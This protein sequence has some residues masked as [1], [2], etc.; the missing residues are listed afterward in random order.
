MSIIRMG[1]VAMVLAA[2]VSSVW[3]QSDLDPAF[4]VVNVTGDCK[5]SLPGANDFVE[6]VESK[7]YP[8][9]SHIRTGA[10][11]SLVAIISEGN[12]VR[13]L[14]N[15]DVVFNHNTDDIKIKNIRL[16]DGEVEVDL[17]STFSE[18]GN[19][20]NVETATAICGAVGTKFNVGSRIVEDMRVVIMRVIRGIIRVHGENF[21]VLEMDADDVFSVLSPADQSYLRMKTMKGK[22]N[23]TFKDEKMEDKNVETTEGMVLKVW[24]R[25]VPESNQRIIH[26]QLLAPDGTQAGEFIFTYGGGVAPE[27]GKDRG[28]NPPWNEEDK[29]PRW[30]DGKPPRRDGEPG[31][32][33]PPDHILNDIVDLVDRTLNEE[34]IEFEQ[35][36]QQPR[37]QPPTPTPAGRR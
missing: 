2:L 34:N 16:N 20:L 18:G 11:S 6:A 30:R 13:V 17:K 31:N 15:A 25:F 8:Y 26:V 10:R 29:K 32:P 5:I 12:T 9:G 19:R 36:Q 23:V 21:E 1:C 35:Q 3:A 22:L 4:R 14:A 28:A 27:F 37:P 33:L 7:A 24:Q